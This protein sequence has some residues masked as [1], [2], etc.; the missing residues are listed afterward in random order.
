MKILCSLS[1]IAF[2]A[3]AAFGFEF[4]RAAE[5]VPE[6]GTVVV[7][8]LQD[9][10]G[11]YGFRPPHEHDVVF[12]EGSK[13]V[14]LAPKKDPKSW[15][16]IRPAASTNSPSSGLRA[17]VQS[18]YRCDVQEQFA[19]FSGGGEAQAGDFTDTSAGAVPLKRR[20][21]LLKSPSGTFEFLLSS[22]ADHFESA[23]RIFNQLVGSFE[24]RTTTDQAAGP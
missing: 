6:V 3:S 23:E 22:R 15:M 4:R 9:A 17:Y 14:T 19:M 16:T 13:T 12:D 2:V 10:K 18:A 24:F 7:C 1:A 21:A 11:S 20:I 5:Q 8:I